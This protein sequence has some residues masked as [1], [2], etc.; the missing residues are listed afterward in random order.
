MKPK[1]WEIKETYSQGTEKKWNEARV[2][3]NE[4]DIEVNLT[5]KFKIITEMEAQVLK[6]IE[7]VAKDFI[8]LNN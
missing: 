5:L 2:Q 8:I 4:S 7:I 6:K 3:K 1:D